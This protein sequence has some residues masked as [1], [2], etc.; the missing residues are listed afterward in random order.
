MLNKGERKTS[1]CAVSSV[2]PKLE[3]D[4]RAA[5]E[6]SRLELYSAKLG[7]HVRTD[8]TRTG[9]ETSSYGGL[10]LDTILTLVE[11]VDGGGGNWIPSRLHASAEAPEIEI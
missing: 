3:Y 5:T 11:R 1:E 7:R 9:F 10:G 6:T 8:A 2:S 4:R